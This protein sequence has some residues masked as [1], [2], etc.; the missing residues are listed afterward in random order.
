MEITGKRIILGVTGSIAAYKAVYLLRLLI[1]E[2]ADVQV[3]MTPFAREFVGPVTFSTLSGK[4]VRS[5]FFRSEGGDWNS[6]VDMGVSSD[7]MIIAPVTAATLGKMA[8]GVA[9]NLLITTYLSARCPVVVA[10][11]MDMDMYQHPSTQRNLEVLTGYGNHVIEPVQ[12][13]LASGLEGRGRMEEPEEIIRFIRLLDR[14]PSK[15]KLLNKQV[16]ITAGPTHESIDPVRYIGNHSSG[17]MG[18]AI[19]EAFAVEGAS[20]YLVSGPVDVKIRVQGVEII[21]V[22]SAAEMH[23]ACK[24]LIDSVDIAVFNAAVA[25]FTPVDVSLQKVKRGGEEWNIRLKPTRDIAAEMGKLK[26]TGQFF[27][28][29]ALETDN[30]LEHA[31]SKL[32]K[33]NLD[34]IVLNSLQQKGAGF[35]TDTNRVTMIDSSGN[36]NEYGLKPKSQVAA[37]LVDR[38][39]KMIE[40]A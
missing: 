30:E 26:Q 3:I 25:D 12:G 28:G 9:D 24:E 39:V 21:D 35:G 10:P 34:L 4:P 2:G 8:N 1:K 38:V 32:A 37:D 13:E 20:V 11:A 22:T 5:E 33:K 31:R 14:Q 27:V 6:H 23:E 7:L 29:F 18:Y 17:K 40:N 19:A 15:K 36:T 16:L